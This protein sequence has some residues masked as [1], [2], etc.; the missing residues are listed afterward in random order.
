MQQ[1]QFVRVI[2]AKFRAVMAFLEGRHMDLLGRTP[3]ED[4][5]TSIRRWGVQGFHLSLSCLSL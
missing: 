4:F 1:K 5:K 3:T 2:N